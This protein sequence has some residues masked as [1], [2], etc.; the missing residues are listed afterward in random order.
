MSHHDC[1]QP[2]SGKI[3]RP[4]K[5][6]MFFLPQRPYCTLG[7]LR[8]QITYPSSQ[9][10]V[11]DEEAVAEGDEGAAAAEG[12]SKEDDEEL[13]ALLEKVGETKTTYNVSKTGVSMTWIG[14]GRGREGLLLRGKRE[15]DEALLLEET[16][17][18]GLV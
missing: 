9:G 5:E 7:P 8:D 10:A 2:G 13:L 1:F 16:R 4:T 6:E 17:R 15:N 14:G 18:F 11:D 3:V 12:T